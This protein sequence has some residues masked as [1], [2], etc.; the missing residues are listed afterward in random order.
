MLPFKRDKIDLSKLSPEEQRLFALYGKIPS[1]KGLKKMQERKY[2][3]SGDYALSKAGRAPQSIVGTAIPNPENIP[4]ASSAGNGHSNGHQI[5]SISPTNSTS[6]VNKES[7]LANDENTKVPED[8][9]LPESGVETVVDQTNITETTETE[10]KPTGAT[11]T[12]TT[13]MESKINK[14]EISATAVTL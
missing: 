2:F 4:H 13:T 11:T 14:T 9:Q 3:D 6:P 1:H 12:E 5:I 10:V 8:G 7:G